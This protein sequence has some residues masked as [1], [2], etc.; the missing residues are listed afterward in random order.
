MRETIKIRRPC[1]ARGSGGMPPEK[2]FKV[3]VSEMAF[4][5]IDRTSMIFLVTK[6]WWQSNELLN[7]C[8]SLIEAAGN[9]TDDAYFA[10]TMKLDVWMTCI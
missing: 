1:I 6:Q 7:Q 8:Q 5:V 9:K 3:W 2:I 10:T 4:P